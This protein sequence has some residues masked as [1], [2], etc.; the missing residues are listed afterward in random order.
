MYTVKDILE[1]KGYNCITVEP[2]ATVY[3]ALKK[4]A[5]HNIGAVL[6]VS[7]NKVIGIFSERDY[8]RKIILMGKTS[9]DSKVG[10]LMTDVVFAVKLNTTIQVCMKLM[11]ENR[12]RHLSV[13]DDDEVLIGVVSIGDIVNKTIEDHK[14]TINQLEDYIV[15][16]R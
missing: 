12:V 14:N 7:N 15:G 8:A 16:K 3:D 4:M 13:F 1:T 5:G 6:V 2:D 11:T 9:R 10:D